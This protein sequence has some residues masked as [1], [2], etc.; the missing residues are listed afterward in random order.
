MDIAEMLGKTLAFGAGIRRSQ[1]QEP[2]ADEP[3]EE[4]E[5]KPVTESGGEW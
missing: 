1:S 4:P 5:V 3:A 2:E